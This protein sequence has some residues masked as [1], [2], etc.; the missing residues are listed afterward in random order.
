MID[1]V[2]WS[3]KFYSCVVRSKCAKF[4]GKRQRFDV[5]KSLVTKSPAG[6]V[7]TDPALLQRFCE[8]MHQKDIHLLPNF[9]YRCVTESCF[10]GI[11]MS[12]ACGKKN[13]R[14]SNR[15][16]GG[17]DANPNEWPWVAAIVSCN[18]M[19]IWRHPR[20]DNSSFAVGLNKW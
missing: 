12:P 11:I 8:L 4:G 19:H 2:A 14:I 20:N 17:Q 5:T 10:Y 1:C 7:R 16:I 18:Q 3:S 6:I 9:I 13:E 15:I